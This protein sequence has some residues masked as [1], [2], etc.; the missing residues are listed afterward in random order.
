MNSHLSLDKGQQAHMLNAIALLARIYWG[1]DPES[2]RQM[3]EGTF[4]EPLEALGRLVNYNPPGRLAELKAGPAGFV[5]H[6][7]L[8]EHLEET[9]IRFFINNRNGAIIPLYASCHAKAQ[10]GGQNAPLMGPAAVEMKKRLE[11]R[12]LSPG[13]GI[14]E[15]PDHICIELEYL[16]FL[17]EKGWMNNDRELIVEAVSF[18]AETML[19][20]I[21]RLQA[22]LADIETAD[23]FY[24]PI[25]AILVSL[26][27]FIADSGHN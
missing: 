4:L 13:D 9:Y 3:L 7:A 22:R 2:S 6:N 17:L 5:D 25:T 14:H 21:M 10:T 12:G 26:L 24:G 16:Y 11:A 23:R 27:Q 19:P 18:S 8:F 20:W 1:P 15:P